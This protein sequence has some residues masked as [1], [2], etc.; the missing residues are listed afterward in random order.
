ML[1]L[2]HVGGSALPCV[3]GFKL[4]HEGRL[5]WKGL[6][7]REKVTLG[8]GLRNNSFTHWKSQRNFPSR[9]SARPVFFDSVCAG[10]DTPEFCVVV[11][12]IPLSYLAADVVMV[13]CLMW[14]GRF[15]VG[16][17]SCG[18]HR[19][20]PTSPC[21]SH[22]KYRGCHIHSDGWGVR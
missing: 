7:A 20:G 13:S 1:L 21:R 12:C 17:L 15:M 10:A 3:R 2:S 8:K 16:P 14:E 9:T 19:Q 4:A 22:D 11:V 18:R 5:R 6:V